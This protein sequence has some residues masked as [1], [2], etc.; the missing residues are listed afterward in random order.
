VLGW[1]NSDSFLHVCALQFI[2][3]VPRAAAES[4]NVKDLKVQ[5]VVN[6]ERLFEGDENG[7]Q[8][9]HMAARHG[10]VDV[11]DFLLKNGA[12]VDARTAKESG[13]YSPLKIALMTLG[14][15]HPVVSLLEENGGHV[16]TEEDDDEL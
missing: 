11:V 6:K 8:P 4:N 1:L 15:D 14:Q 12:D 13:S 9:I 2:P 10:H 3:V 7:W 16:L 5:L